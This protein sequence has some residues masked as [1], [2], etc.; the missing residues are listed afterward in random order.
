MNKRPEHE[1]VHER[2]ASDEFQE[3]LFYRGLS[4]IKW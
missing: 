1:A 2:M 3:K 4:S